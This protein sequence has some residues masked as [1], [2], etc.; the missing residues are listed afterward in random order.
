MAT[1]NPSSE[2]RRTEKNSK[3]N[4]LGKAGATKTEEIQTREDNNKPE[5][6]AEK[7]KRKGHEILQKMFSNQ[8]DFQENL[9]EK[10][11]PQK[12]RLALKEEIE[13][14]IR[15]PE[16][17]KSLEPR[18][19]I[20]LRT[21]VDGSDHR[22][23]VFCQKILSQEDAIHTHNKLTALLVSLEMEKEPMD[24]DSPYSPEFRARVRKAYADRV[25]GV[26]TEPEDPA[27]EEEENG[28]EEVDEPSTEDPESG[29]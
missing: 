26:T 14:I 1:K 18:D 4:H 10:I 11:R 5:T 28:G 12:D 7:I 27:D 23:M 13:K 6:P 29:D 3:K 8:C 2:P 16:F 21:S 17:Y 24:P 9:A 20:L 19:L 25:T 15:D 22:W